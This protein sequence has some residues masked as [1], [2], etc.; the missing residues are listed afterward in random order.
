M[1][2]LVK[3]D[4]LRRAFLRAATHHRNAKAINQ[5]EK[6]SALRRHSG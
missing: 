6:P 5:P 2:A 3:P 1:F 4:G